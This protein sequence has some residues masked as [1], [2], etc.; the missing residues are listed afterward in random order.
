[1]P[2]PEELCWETAIITL[3]PTP[4]RRGRYAP[5]RNIHPGL[6]LRSQHLSARQEIQQGEFLAPHSTYMPGEIKSHP[7]CS[8][9]KTKVLETRRGWEL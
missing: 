5:P 6:P 8:L 2:G 1:V 9:E 4:I 7:N 3:L